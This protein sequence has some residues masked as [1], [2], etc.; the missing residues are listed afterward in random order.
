MSN[1]ACILFCCLYNE[2]YKVINQKGFEMERL[3]F[4]REQQFNCDIKCDEIFTKG[5][6]TYVSI[7][8]WDFD[9]WSIDGF[10]KVEGDH[11]FQLIEK[12]YQE[13]SS[14][15]LE[16]SDEELDYFKCFCE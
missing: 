6:F 13:E 3:E 8:S 16:C 7:L 15:L 1:N 2:N 14:L 9:N 11:D 12:L 10:F 5:N 4:Y